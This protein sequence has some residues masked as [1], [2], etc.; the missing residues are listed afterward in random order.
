[1]STPDEPGVRQHPWQ[2]YPL[3]ETTP[4]LAEIERL[5]EP[6]EGWLQRDTGVG[7]YDLVLEQAPSA[8]VVEIGVYKGRSAIWLASALRDRGAGRL[9]AIDHW[10]T[11]TYNEHAHIDDFRARGFDGIY[12][13]FLANLERA[14]VRDLVEPWR[15]DSRE[16]ALRWSHGA[17]IGLLHIDGD[18]EYLGARADFEMWAPYV[19]RG[20][21]VVFDDV[22]SWFGPSRVISELPAY[23]RYYGSL[24]NKWIVQRQL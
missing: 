11:M 12:Q 8:T 16:A 9:Y 19:M 7:I 21:F 23:W 4:R 13:D 2:G 15:M 24:P 5:A 14:Q 18:H 6:A 1:M 17:A 10:A 3:P 22:V 20:G